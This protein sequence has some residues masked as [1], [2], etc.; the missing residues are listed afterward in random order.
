MSLPLPVAG[1]AP[2]CLGPQ[3]EP[4]APLVRLPQGSVDAHCHIF[5]NPQRFPWVGNRTYTPAPAPLS[6][7]LKM[8]ETVGFTRTVQVNASI[9][10]FDNN[11]TLEAIAQLGQHRARGVVGV[12]PNVTV[13]ELTRLHEGGIRGVRLS[14][15]VAGYGGTDLLDAIAKRIQPLG[16]HVQL[17]VANAQELVAL[18]DRLLRV[19]TPLVFDHLGC[20]HGR[21]GVTSAG[22][23]VLLRMLQARDDC[24]V[25][26]SSWYRRSSAGAPLYRDMKP[27]V[28]ALVKSRPDRLLFGSNWPHPNLFPPDVVPDEGDLV[29]VFNDWVPDVA[30]RQKILVRNPEILYGFSP[31]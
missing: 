3:A 27:L 31:L 30:Q 4:K 20:V 29:D 5:E 2:V 26:I 10:G 8:C 17:H 13:A 23:Q 7:Y 15:H 16:W 24:W 9:Y 12:A 22:F 18:E 1:D 28:D 19:S 25:K 11:I 6:R 14:T 21:D